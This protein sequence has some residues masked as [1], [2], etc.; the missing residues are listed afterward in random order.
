MYDAV[1]GRFVSRDPVG[2]EVSSWYLYRCYF[3]PSS[4]EPYGDRE[5]EE[6]PSSPNFPSRP[7]M[8]SYRP[9]PPLSDLCNGIQAC[10]MCDLSTCLAVQSEI[11]VVFAAA[12]I[13]ALNGFILRISNLR[14]LPG[15]RWCT[16]FRRQ[17]TSVRILS[18]T[19]LYTWRMKPVHQLSPSQPVRQWGMHGMIRLS[20]SS[21][22]IVGFDE[23]QYRPAISIQSTYFDRADRTNGP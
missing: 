19:F 9:L 13:N 17:V 3:A 20:S 2:F 7:P 21:S 4:R 12:K 23:R 5:F 6:D 22:A 1:G 10:G 15:M 11:Q 18:T 14:S 16:A 8:L